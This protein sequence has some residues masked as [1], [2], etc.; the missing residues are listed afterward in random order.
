MVSQTE[1]EHIRM[2]DLEAITI[3]FYGKLHQQMR[4][5]HILFEAGVQMLETGAKSPHRVT[6]RW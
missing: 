5:F 2:P 6:T 3:L 4:H 1:D